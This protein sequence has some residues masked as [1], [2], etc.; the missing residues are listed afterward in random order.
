[1]TLTT[2]KLAA[3]HGVTTRTVRA[4]TRAGCPTAGQAKRGP[5]GGR[6]ELLF[7]ARAVETWLAARG[8]FTPGMEGRAIRG[9]FTSGPDPLADFDLSGLDLDT[10]PDYVLEMPPPAP[11]SRADAEAVFNIRITDPPA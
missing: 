9:A 4:W 11:M 2:A 10:F 8:T 3:E 5:R 7:D 1:L 6:P